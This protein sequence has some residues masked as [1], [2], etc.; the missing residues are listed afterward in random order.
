MVT[1]AVGQNPVLAHVRAGDAEATPVG[2]GEGVVAG[3]VVTGQGVTTAAGEA[4]TSAAEGECANN[5]AEGMVAGLA[6]PAPGSR[7]HPPREA[8]NA[9]SAATCHRRV[10]DSLPIMSV[11]H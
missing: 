7:T 6:D 11:R 2:N 4:V 3:G 5:A 1:G 8:T 9:M 10:M